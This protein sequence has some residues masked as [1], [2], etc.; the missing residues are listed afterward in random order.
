M[1]H[2]QS[3]LHKE[4]PADMIG[5]PGICPAQIE[6]REWLEFVHG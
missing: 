2:M 5:A 3:S 4:P 1:D 6:G